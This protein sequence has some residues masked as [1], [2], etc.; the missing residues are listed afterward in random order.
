MARKFRWIKE[1]K[2]YIAKGWAEWHLYVEGWDY[3]LAS[4]QRNGKNDGYMILL[5]KGRKEPGRVYYHITDY[6]NL[7]VEWYPTLDE[8]KRAV[9][10]RFGLK[11]PTKKKISAP[12]GL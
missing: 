2:S 3:R 11:R 12:F 4:I 9:E 1:D 6:S 5:G 10:R 7:S 8:A